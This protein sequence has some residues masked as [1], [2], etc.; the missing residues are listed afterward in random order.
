MVLL[1]LVGG[2]WCELG[3]NS[4]ASDSNQ[5]I[6]LE[7]DKGLSTL[8]L[9]SDSIVLPPHPAGVALG[10]GWV[11]TSPARTPVCRGVGLTR[12]WCNMVYW[13]AHRPFERY[14]G[15]VVAPGRRAV[16]NSR[17][18]PRH[19]TTRQVVFLVSLCF[20]PPLAFFVGAF[21]ITLVV[22]LF[23]CFLCVSHGLHPAHGADSNSFFFWNRCRWWAG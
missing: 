14:D 2:V 3:F 16:P 8:D 11:L 9:S 21:F 19:D 18:A 13:L 7:D 22:H 5:S 17:V 20:S 4:A 6:P 12:T 1:L 15:T 10:G 23:A